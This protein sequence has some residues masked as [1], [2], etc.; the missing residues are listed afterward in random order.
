MFS[1]FVAWLILFV[2]IIVVAYI[3]PGVTVR[4]LSAAAITAAVLGILNA[5]I[6]PILVILTLPITILTFGLFLLVINALLFMLASAIVPGFHV[7][8]FWWALLGSVIVSVV[9]YVLQS[10]VR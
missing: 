3:L 2:A 1:I 5:L 9:S 4:S 10:I 7:K 6:K 8:S